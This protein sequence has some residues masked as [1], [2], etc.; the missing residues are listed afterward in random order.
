MK[1]KHIFTGQWIEP[2]A[3]QA[4]LQV[5]DHYYIEQPQA[6]LLSTNNPD[7]FQSKYQ[8]PPVYGRIESAEN[9]PTGYF[10]VEGFS[11][12]C[13]EGEHGLMCIVEPSR[14]LTPEEF[15]RARA[16]GWPTINRTQEE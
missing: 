14:K 8:T 3:W 2:E 1:F 15:E 16:A 6:M 5:G 10:Y 9:C 11:Q 4:D 7:E 12:W 13:P